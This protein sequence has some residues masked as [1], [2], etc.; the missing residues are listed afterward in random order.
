[1][2]RIPLFQIYHGPEDV[3]RVA[4]AIESGMNWAVGP[5]VEAFERGLAGFLGVEHAVTLNSG[6]SALHAALL[7][8]GIG[9]GDEVIVPS[10]TF[11]ATANAPLFT[12]ARP[13]FADIEP[14]T[15]G[16]DPED[17]VERITPKT[18]A[19]IPVH[20]GGCPCRIRELAELAEDHDLVLLEDAAEAFGARSGNKH[21]GTFGDAGVLS[22]CQNKVITTGEGGAVVTDDRNIAERCRLLRSHGRPDAVDYFSSPEVMDYIT[23]GYN[24]RLSNLSAALGLAQLEKADTIIRLRR[25]KASYYRRKIRKHAPACTVRDEPAGHFVVYQIFSIETPKRD[26]LMAYLGKQGIMTKIYFPPVHETSYYRDMLGYECDLPV[27]NRVA[28]SILS[29]PMHPGIP[30]NDMNTVVRAIEAFYSS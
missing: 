25:Q 9:P 12:G 18:R 7:T 26:G 30:V 24:F 14:G 5:Q 3:E 2:W 10:F 6:T 21:V 20:Y 16:L 15:Y 23:L 1:M 29:L 4:A 17:V 11:I 13:V 27:T 8:L 19:I 28:S 22:F